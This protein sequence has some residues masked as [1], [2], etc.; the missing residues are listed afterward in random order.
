MVDLVGLTIEC[1]FIKDELSVYNRLVECFENH[2]ETYYKCIFNKK[3]LN[4]KMPQPQ[5]QRNGFPIIE[6]MVLF[7]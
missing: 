1:R 2:D 4:L 6:L 7:Y 3:C 5:V